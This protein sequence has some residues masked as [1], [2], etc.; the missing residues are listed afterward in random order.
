[1]EKKLLNTILIKVSLILSILAVVVVIIL[2]VKVKEYRNVSKNYQKIMTE[3][4]RV[5]LQIG[6]RLGVTQLGARVT[7]ESFEQYPPE[8]LKNTPKENIIEF[9]FKDGKTGYI[10]Y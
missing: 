4:E 6:F 1:M 2:S 9:Q 5:A 3:R 7:S 8:M 10:L